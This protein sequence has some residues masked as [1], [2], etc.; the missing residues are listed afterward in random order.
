MGDTQRVG[1]TREGTGTPA[2]SPR[3]GKGG[4]K[5]VAGRG[6]GGGVAQP[7][8]TEREQVSYRPTGGARRGIRRWERGAATSRHLPNGVIEGRG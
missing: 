4:E 8:R 5:Q 7:L 1:C 3:V 6:L 2:V